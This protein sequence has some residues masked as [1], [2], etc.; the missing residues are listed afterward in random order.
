MSQV[1]IS[2]RQTDYTQKQR[3]RAFAERLRDAGIDVILD[4]FFLD[5]NPAGPNEGW[6]KW[7]N[8]RARQTENVLII[9]T[10]DWFESFEKTNEPG[11]GLGSSYEGGAVRRRTELG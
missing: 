5:D 3:V 11:I 9:G 6:P 8:D 10:H 2:Y 4:Q 1:F 7:S